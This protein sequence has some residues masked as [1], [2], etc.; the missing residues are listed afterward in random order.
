MKKILLLST[1]LA[2]TLMFGQTLTEKQMMNAR[3]TGYAI[4]AAKNP[5]LE[6]GV[7]VIPWDGVNSL[8]YNATNQINY[9]WHPQVVVKGNSFDQPFDGSDFTRYSS[10]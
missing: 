1:I 9:A 3:A 6:F 4:I 5:G 2:A 10:F 7:L 8:E